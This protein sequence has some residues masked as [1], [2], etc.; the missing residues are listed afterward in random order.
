MATKC[1]GGFRCNAL[2]YYAL[3]T[4]NDILIHFDYIRNG[5]IDRIHQILSICI[6]V[7]FITS[8]VAVISEQL[9]ATDMPNEKDQTLPM[10]QHLCKA[11]I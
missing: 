5:Y 6:H 4:L 10:Q 1:C 7:P 9:F 8:F 3:Q 11:N 2:R